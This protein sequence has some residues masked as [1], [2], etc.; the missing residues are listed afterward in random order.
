MGRYLNPDNRNYSRAVRSGIYVE[1][2]GM[3]E[4]LN[5]V[6]DTEQCWVCV[7]RPRR[8]GKTITADMLAAYYS[9]AFSDRK[10]S[11]SMGRV[12]T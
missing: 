8:F 3:L 11:S 2:T 5:Q 10:A 6:M 7:S 4:H 9:R 12:T 1:K